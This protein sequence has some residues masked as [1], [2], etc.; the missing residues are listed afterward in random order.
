MEK[1]MRRELKQHPLVIQDSHSIPSFTLIPVFTSQ[2]LLSGLMAEKAD[3]ALE[4]RNCFDNFFSVDFMLLSID[5]IVKSLIHRRGPY[6]LPQAVR[7]PLRNHLMLLSYSLGLYTKKVHAHSS[8]LDY[9]SDDYV[10]EQIALVVYIHKD[11]ALQLYVV[12]SVPFYCFLQPSFQTEKKV[13]FNPKRFKSLGM[14]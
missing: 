2:N 4:S 14:P 6:Q 1:K 9:R 13:R 10:P 12:V 11:K 3:M 7:L 5:V 8:P